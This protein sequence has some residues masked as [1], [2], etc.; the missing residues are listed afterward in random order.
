MPTHKTAAFDAIKQVAIPIDIRNCDT[1]Q[2]IP[3]RFLKVEPESENYAQCLFH[4]LRFDSGGEPIDDFIFNDERYRGAGILVADHNWGCGSSREQAVWVLAANNIRCVIAPS[5][6]DIH[7][8]NC[9]NR[10][11]LPVVLAES[12]CERLRQHL[13]EAAG[14]EITVDLQQQTVTAIN[15]SVFSFVIDAFDKQRLLKGLDEIGLTQQF[16]S[17]IDKF[18]R[19]RKDYSWL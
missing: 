6:A 17:S 5:F 14:E 11:I 12:D 7:Y 9:V 2:I 13:H 16:E 10:G 18:E 8:N 15:G 3:A 19:Q 1:D 4:D